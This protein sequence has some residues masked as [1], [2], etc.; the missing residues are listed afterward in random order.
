MLLLHTYAALL[1]ICPFHQLL[2]V[3]SKANESRHVRATA[4]NAEGSRSHSILGLYVENCNGRSKKTTVGKLSLI[5]LAGEG[6]RNSGEG[7]P[8]AR[9]YLILIHLLAPIIK[10]S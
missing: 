7:G 8:G 9:V 3:L 4:M 6:E 5:D 1:P 10:H 2:R